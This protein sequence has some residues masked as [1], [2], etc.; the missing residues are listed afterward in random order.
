MGSGRSH[1]L[2]YRL[3]YPQA[4]V[5][6]RVLLSTGHGYLAYLPVVIGVVAAAQLV[7]LAVT[8]ADAALRRPSRPLPGWGFALLPPLAFVLQEL[9]E[10]WL[11]TNSFPWWIVLQPT[12]RLGL[13]LQLPFALAAYVAARMLLRAARRVGAVLAFP[14]L[15]AAAFVRIVSPSPGDVPLP[16]WSSLS[17]GWS[18]RGPPAP[19]V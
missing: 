3:V 8:A 11:A 15:P 2:A 16:R 10:R 4:E 5:R 18:E 7:G 13:L 17:L 14:L 9:S 12:F 19:S 1:A 6:V